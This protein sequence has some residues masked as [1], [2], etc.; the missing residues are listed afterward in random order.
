MFIVFGVLVV[1]VVGL[2]LV[3]GG[4]PSGGPDE[5]AG[6]RLVDPATFVAGIEE[7]GTFVVNV[8]VPYEGEIA[9]TDAFVPFDRIVGDD[10]LPSDRGAEILLYCRSGRMSGIAARAL[11]DAGY[12]NI[13]DLDGGMIAWEAAGLPTLQRSQ[14]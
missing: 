2:V 3:V 12:T 8:H 5:V 11:A 1:I 14:G 7:P 4:R 13:V 9:G 6:P 10:L